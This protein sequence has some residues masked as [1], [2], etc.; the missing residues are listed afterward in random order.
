VGIMKS[1]IVRFQEP[2]LAGQ[3]FFDP[4]PEDLVTITDSGK[5]RSL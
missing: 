5:G 2:Y 1:H 4:Y 3:N